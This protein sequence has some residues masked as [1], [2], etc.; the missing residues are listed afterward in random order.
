MSAEEYGEKLIEKFREHTD[1]D[2][3]AA[4]FAI[5]LLDE[6]IDKWIDLSFCVADSPKGLEQVSKGIDFMQKTKKYL[7]TK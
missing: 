3:D 6:M 7:E 1:F 5:V 4:Q 2:D